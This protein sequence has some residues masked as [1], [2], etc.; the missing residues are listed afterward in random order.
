MV[1]GRENMNLLHVRVNRVFCV[2][3]GATTKRSAYLANGKIYKQEQNYKYVS[4]CH[5]LKCGLIMLYGY[6][7]D[8]Y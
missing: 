3:L 7:I 6:L 8:I 2:P 5:A 4:N 1:V